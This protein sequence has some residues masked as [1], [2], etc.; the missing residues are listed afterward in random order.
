[1]GIKVPLLGF[2]PDVDQ[3]TPGAIVDCDQ[4]VPSVRGIRSAP[5][6]NS[7][8]LPATSATVTGAA[9]I[10]KLDGSTR[11][12]AGSSAKIEEATSATAWTD[13]SASGGYTGTEPWRFAQFGDVTLAT[14]KSQ[15]IQYSTT[16][17]FAT[18]SGAP[19]AAIIETVNNFVFA[20]DTV[21]GTFGTH[22]DGWWCSALN[23]YSDWTPDIQTQS[24]RNNLKSVPGPITAGRRLGDSIVVY[25][26]RGM[27]VG[28]YVGA[29]LIWN[30]QEIPGGI[31][32]FSHEAVV[33][34]GNAAHVFVG[35]DDFYWFDGS[36]PIPIGDGIREFFFNDLDKAN[37]KRIKGLHD[38][39]NKLIYF[40]YPS[41]GGGGAV[42][43]CVV[44][45]YQTKRWGLADRAIEVA[46]EYVAANV[47][48]DSLGSLYSTYNDLPSIT[49]DAFFTAGRPVPAIFN[50]SHVIQTLN[51]VTSSWWFKTG[52]F[53]DESK[54]TTVL[55]IK[56]RFKV[57]P[58][59]STLTNYYRYNTSE[60]RLGNLGDD[61]VEDVTTTLTRG[62]YDFMR[63]ALWHAGKFSGTGNMEQYDFDVEG[64]E[65]GLE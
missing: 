64:L 7:T 51:G 4:I 15:P 5:G 24:A 61:Q 9:V 35:Y 62:S 34:V 13:Q 6:V 1:M 3:S 44:Y 36:R 16:A 2:M 46:V 59:T 19:S 11:L 26:Q 49:Y 28:T 47:S 10:A 55:Q 31:G 22:P 58:T 30:F 12:F 21:D 37:A 25:K 39:E 32:A 52:D 23:D 45:N 38:F 50:S 27:Y 14:N 57:K 43:S 53:G 60:D 41:V 29:P 63:G 8:G 56:P 18:V 20:L 42:D 40:Y 33:P 48:Y 65:T 54:V 17:S